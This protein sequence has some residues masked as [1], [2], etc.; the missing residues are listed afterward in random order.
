MRTLLP[1]GEWAFDAA[2]TGQSIS[3]TGGR[4][5]DA[6]RLS[7]G[8]LGGGTVYYA[9]VLVDGNWVRVALPWSMTE[10]DRP[11]AVKS[12]AELVFEG[13]YG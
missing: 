5:T 2:V 13:V 10:G 8:P 1:G 9:D 3:T 6:A 4:T 7:E 11:A 12:I